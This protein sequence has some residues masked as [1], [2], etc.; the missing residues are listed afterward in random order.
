MF[1]FGN[2]TFFFGNRSITGGN[3]KEEDEKVQVSN[4]TFLTRFKVDFI[5]RF[6]FSSSFI[7]HPGQKVH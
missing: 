2:S 7:V 4:H 5:Q 6:P 3:R 1:S